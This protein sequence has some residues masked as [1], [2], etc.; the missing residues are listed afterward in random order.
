MGRYIYAPSCVSLT[1]QS[2]EVIGGSACSWTVPANVTSATFEVWGGGGASGVKCCCYCTT[3]MG[4]GAGGYALKTVTVTP[5]SIYSITAGAGGAQYYCS[6]TATGCPGGASYVTGTG[7]SN[8][9]ASG[10]AGGYGTYALCVTQC[11]CSGTGYGGDVN[12][13]GS[14]AW[15]KSRSS[16]FCSLSG[17][18]AS[19]FGG[20]ESHYQSCQCC[21]MMGHG[22]CGM[23]PGGGGSGFSGCCCDCCVCNG[24]GALGLVRITF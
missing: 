21:P 19:P 5:G 4:G 15:N 22:R 8:F 9:C 11:A 24:G 23:F 12:L 6:S 18:A 14:V 20:G 10:G 3:G 1:R 17:G 13:A 2:V 7:L 16:S